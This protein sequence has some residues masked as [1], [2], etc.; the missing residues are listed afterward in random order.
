MCVRC[1]LGVARSPDL[2]RSGGNIYGSASPFSPWLC[3]LAC[4]LCPVRPPLS[5]PLEG[6]R[7]A[8]LSTPQLPW[9]SASNHS[10]FGSQTAKST[11]GALPLPWWPTPTSIIIIF[12]FRRLCFSLWCRRSTTCSIWGRSWS[13]LPWHWE[14]CSLLPDTM[15]PP[16]RPCLLFILQS[17][18]LPSLL[19][20]SIPS[21]LPPSPSLSSQLISTLLPSRE[22]PA[23]TCPLLPPTLY[24]RGQTQWG[25]HE[26]VWTIL[27]SFD[28]LMSSQWLTFLRNLLLCSTVSAGHH[29]QF[30]VH[31][32]ESLLPRRWRSTACGTS[33]PTDRCVHWSLPGEH[34]LSPE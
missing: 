15:R 4:I 19:V 20:P 25:G 9:G 29:S 2:R 32:R 5:C 26:P 23:P 21:P 22:R 1:P 8:L 24:P 13:S 7:I 30:P 12:V 28:S 18:E 10:T 11:S 34:F 6:W 17:A 33:V 27:L 31:S 3:L 16:V 14:H